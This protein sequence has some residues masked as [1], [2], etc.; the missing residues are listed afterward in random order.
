VAARTFLWW[1][2]LCMQVTGRRLAPVCLEVMRAVAGNFR[3]VL[4]HAVTGHERTQSIPQRQSLRKKEEHRHQPEP[5]TKVTAH[6][7]NLPPARSV[8]ARLQSLTLRNWRD[9]RRR[10]RLRPAPRLCKEKPASHAERLLPDR[11]RRRRVR[12]SLQSVEAAPW[13]ARLRFY[14]IPGNGGSLSSLR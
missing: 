10:A 4:A 1:V 7:H 3:A 12:G 2:R 5:P 14:F 11:I 8:A 9:R 13:R 6:S